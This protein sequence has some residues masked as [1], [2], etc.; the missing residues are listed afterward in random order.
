MLD[1]KIVRKRP[2]LAAWIVHMQ[3]TTMNQKQFDVMILLP[4]SNVKAYCLN[5]LPKYAICGKPESSKWIFNIQIQSFNCQNYWYAWFQCIVENGNL[6]TKS[7]K[8]HQT[9]WNQNES[10]TFKLSIFTCLLCE[11]AKVQCSEDFLPTCIHVVKP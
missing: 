6:K 1:F 10:A 8:S 5:N 9:K 7:K 2:K 3:N 4:N 11:H